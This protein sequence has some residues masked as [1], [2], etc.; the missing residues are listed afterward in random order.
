MEAKRLE[1]QQG[2]QWIKKGYALFMQ[3]PLLWIVLLAICF[4]TAAGVNAIPLVGEPLVSLLMPV[5]IIGLMAGCRSLDQGDELEL[6]HLFCGFQRHTSHLVTLGGIA[7]VGQYLIF[8]VMMAVG[9]ATLVGILMS[10]QA[11]SSPD[12]LEQAIAGAGAAVMIG[13]ALFSLLLMSMQFAPML[14]Y[15]RGVP[16][17]AAMKLS[18]SAFTRNMGAMFIYGMAFM[19][20][21]VLASM[22]MMLGWL[23]LAPMVFTSLYASFCDIFP[24][25]V[26]INPQI[27][28]G[29]VITRDEQ[30]HF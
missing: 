11:P 3:A 29:E 24:P 15:F 23:I 9:G 1:A 5:A 19:L 10:N 14:V 7:L 26:D 13:I 6:M 4:V 22:P 20:L 27:I 30:E 12:V 17:V 21:A 2:W 25:E 16:P 8:G 18:L 28:E